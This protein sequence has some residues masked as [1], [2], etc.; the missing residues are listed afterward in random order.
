MAAA[1]NN[2]SIYVS[3]NAGNTWSTNNLPRALWH[4]LALSADGSRI[5]GVGGYPYTSTDFGATWTTNNV[6]GI[7]AA[8]CSA[9]GNKIIGAVRYNGGIYVSATS[10]SPR[11][12]LS[13]KNGASFLSWVIPSAPFALQESGSLEV[14]NWTT[15]TNSQS[16]NLSTLQEEVSVPMT[17]GTHFY[18]LSGE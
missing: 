10:P 11:L 1:M 8:A 7:S 6:S 16:L 4:S 3:T 15:V 2:G 18:R 5:I 12:N 9:D 17:G 13:V 14:P